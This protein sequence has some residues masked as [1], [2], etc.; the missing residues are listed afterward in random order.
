M[1]PQYTE[2]T[3]SLQN[4]PVVRNMPAIRGGIDASSETRSPSIF[5][6][7]RMILTAFSRRGFGSESSSSAMYFAL[8]PKRKTSMLWSLSWSGIMFDSSIERAFR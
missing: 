5:N 8:V 6:P 1:P 2:E 7:A 4:V 3:I